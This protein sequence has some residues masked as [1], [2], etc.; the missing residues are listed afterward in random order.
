MP[1][2]QPPVP[3][4]P[5]APPNPGPG[6]TDEPAPRILIETR[7]LSLFYGRAQA[8]KNITLGIRERVVTAFIGPSGCGI[9]SN[10]VTEVAPWR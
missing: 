7:D 8:L 1:T 2:V 4:P 6:H 10:W 9:T 3:T 5:L